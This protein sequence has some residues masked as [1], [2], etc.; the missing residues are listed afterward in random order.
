MEAFEGMAI[1]TT[2]MGSEDNIMFH[3][4]LRL[5]FKL[6]KAEHSV[7]ADFTSGL[8]SVQ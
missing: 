4:Q 1:H 3:L 2:T 5:S 6:S 8:H 7:Y